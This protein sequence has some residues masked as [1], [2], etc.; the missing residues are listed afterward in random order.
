[1]NYTVYILYIL[2]YHQIDT[3]DSLVSY[4]TNTPDLEQQTENYQEKLETLLAEHPE[5]KRPI[6]MEES[7]EAT[8]LDSEDLR[9]ELVLSSS[10]IADC[11]KMRVF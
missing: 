2:I 10:G 9:E 3:Y 4:C 6:K 5:L 7:Q 8:P 1:M 11:A